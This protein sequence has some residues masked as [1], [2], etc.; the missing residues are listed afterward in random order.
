MAK[1]N[2][3]LLSGIAS[4][5]LGDVVFFRRWGSNIARVRVKPANPRTPLQ[6]LVRYNLSALAQAWKGSGDL[7]KQDDATGTITGTSN[8]LYVMLRKY[9]PN[10][11]NYTEVPFIVLS[12]TEQQAWIDYAVNVLKKPSAW[13]RLTFVGENARRLRYNQNPIRTPA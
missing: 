5:K 10:T 4:G 7:V 13:G 2:I 6:Q 11:G 1:V 9:D 12:A 8:A 3:P